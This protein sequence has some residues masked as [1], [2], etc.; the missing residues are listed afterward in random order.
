[1]SHLTVPQIHNWSNYLWWALA[2]VWIGSAPFRK[3]V[4][5]PTS[6]SFNLTQRLVFFCGLYLL[7]APPIAPML[8]ALNTPLFSLTLPIAI[9]GLVIVFAGLAF[10]IWARFTLGS[11]WSAEPSIRHDHELILRGPYRL[12]RHPIYT[13]ILTAMLGSALQL[14]LLRSLLGFIVCVAAL[15]IKLS[16]EEQLM[17]QQFGNRYLEYSAQVR[18]LVPFLY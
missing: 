6:I 14:G 1:M 16:V 4:A 15:L 18:R 8:P 12:V 5:R 9:A 7:F 11:S 2:A 3:P 13:G 10:S 17:V